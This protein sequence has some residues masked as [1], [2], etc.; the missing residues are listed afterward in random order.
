[1][2]SRDT[3]STYKYCGGSV[4]GG[5]SVCIGGI[6]VGVVMDVNSKK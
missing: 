6:C 3:S 5:T 2:T 1:M 4:G